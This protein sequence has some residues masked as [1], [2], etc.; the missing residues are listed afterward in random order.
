VLLLAAVTGALAACAPSITATTP[1][2]NLPDHAAPPATAALA[3]VAILPARAHHDGYTQASFGP[4]WTDDTTSPGGHNDCDTRDD[5]LA[6]DLIVSAWTTTRSC[7]RAVA[8]GTLTD[9][10]TGHT[11]AF[12]RGPQTSA[13][14]QIDHVYPR[15]AAWDMGAWAWAPARRVAFAN[16]PLN[17]QA[18]AGAANDGRGNGCRRP[19]DATTPCG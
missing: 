18:V 7:P 14:V 6:R 16:D 9:L 11:I 13:Q 4:A 15:A 17:L 3:G 12:R 19:T 1:P 8:A 10:Y 5:I 2:A